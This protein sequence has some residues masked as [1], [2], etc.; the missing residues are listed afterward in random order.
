LPTAVA[1]DVKTD[2]ESSGEKESVAFP[3]RKAALYFIVPLTVVDRL[4]PDLSIHCVSVA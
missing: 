3:F 1:I 4:L 2:G